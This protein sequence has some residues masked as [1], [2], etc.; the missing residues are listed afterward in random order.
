MWSHYANGHNG[1]CIELSARAL[2][3]ADFFGQASAVTYQE[4]LP[5]VDYFRDKPMDKVRKAVYTKSSAWFYEREYRL[6]VTQPS[7]SRFFD[8]DP[9]LLTGVYL[10]C[11][12]SE[13]DCQRVA[14]WLKRRPGM[15]A[16]Y[17]AKQADDAYQ[18]EFQPYT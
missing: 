12:V 3:H 10:G 5:V 15:P 8:F 4:D 18:L 13:E 7:A 9:L 17:R 1:I 2:G 11:K 16:L 14:D 6:V